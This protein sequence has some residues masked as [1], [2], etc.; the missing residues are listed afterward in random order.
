MLTGEEGCIGDKAERRRLVNQK[1]GNYLAL[2]RVGVWTCEA[3]SVFCM[4]SNGVDTVPLCWHALQCPWH[5]RGRCLFQHRVDDA[6]VKPPMS[7]TEEET[8]AELATLWAAVSKLEC[9]LMWRT[10][11]EIDVPV[12]QVM[13]EPAT[14]QETVEGMGE[15]TEIIV[16]SDAVD[17]IF[18]REPVQ[19]RTP[20]QIEDVPQFREYTADVVGLVPRER[21]QQPTVEETVN[22]LKLVSQERVQQR[23]AEEIEDFLQYPEETVEV[24]SLAL[25]E[26]VQQWTVDA[27]RPQDNVF[28]IRV[29]ERIFEQGG[30]IEVPETASQHRRLQRTVVQYLDV[31]AEVDKNVLSERISERMRDQINREHLQCYF[32]LWS[33]DVC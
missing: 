27:P 20:E 22:M 13:K 25:H 28:P 19:Q 5:R 12:P 23:R 2:N 11:H 1:F 9:S 26:R 7:R 31:S 4:V 32:K 18:P 21:V 3:L 33:L 17:G 10:G 29:S 15:M 6:G 14:K 8:G 16:V 24:V 30:V